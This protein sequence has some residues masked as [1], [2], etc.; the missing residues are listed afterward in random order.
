MMALKLFKSELNTIPVTTAWFTVYNK[1]K[2]IPAL[3][4]VINM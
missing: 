2:I 1:M 3:L 4:M